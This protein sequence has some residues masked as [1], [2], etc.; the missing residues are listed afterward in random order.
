MCGKIIRHYI[1]RCVVGAAAL[2]VSALIVA[3]SVGDELSIQ[4]QLDNNYDGIMLEPENE[5]DK[6][7]R[8]NINT[9]SAHHLQRINGI[10]EVTAAAVIEYR[11]QHGGFK[12]VDELVNVKGIGNVTLERIR[13]IITV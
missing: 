2:T 10:G 6:S 5:V 12:N 1:K 7:V 9:A 3:N 4:R 13:D 8:V 11:E